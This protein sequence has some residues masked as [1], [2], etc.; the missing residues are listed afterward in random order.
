MA[1]STPL[2]SLSLDDE[3]DE[4][5]H[6]TT[7]HHASSTLLIAPL[8]SRQRSINNNNNNNSNSNIYFE[9]ILFF[10]AGLGSSIGYISSLSSLVYFNILYGNTYFVYLNCIIFLPLLPIS[11]FQSLLDTKFDMKY[12]NSNIT[13]LFRSIIGYGLLILGTIGIMILFW[14]ND[15]NESN[16]KQQGRWVLFMALQQGIGGAILYGQLNQLSSFV[17]SLHSTTATNTNNNDS[18]DDVNNENVSNENDSEDETKIISNK[19][20]ATV[21]AGV[22]ASAIVVLC[23]SIGSGFYDTMTVSA[24]ITFLLWIVLMEILCFMAYLWLL[25]AVPRVQ[26]SMIRRD[27]SMMH[28]EQ[29]MQSQSQSQLLLTTS[30]P[31][32]SSEEVVEEEEMIDLINNDNDFLINN[33]DNEDPMMPLRQPLLLSSSTATASSTTS[34]NNTILSLYEILYHSRYCCLGMGLTLIPSFLVGSWFTR[35]ETDWMMLAQILFYIRIGCDL[36]GRI[37]TLW[38]PPKSISY[39]LWIATI[40]WIAVFLFFINSTPTISIPIVSKVLPTIL[41]PTTQRQRDIVSILLVAYIAFCS[42]YLVTSLYQLAPQQLPSVPV[43][44]SLREE[45]GQEEEEQQQQLLL[46]PREG[47]RQRQGVSN[48]NT[49]NTNTVN[50]TKQSSI[51]TVAFSISAICGLLLSF[52]FIAIGV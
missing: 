24:F 5:Q 36:L 17:G 12:K 27:S 48:T 22:Q 4:D 3:D 41:V 10:M 32:P 45:E 16:S 43:P 2:L 11:I 40:R 38:V 6:H 42:G 37:C 13:F 33:N 46:L 47:Q 19:F 23:I 15:E 7:Q 18:N 9:Q 52:T 25:I 34:D 35:I 26:I 51:L 14:N 44:V 49:N 28:M 30:S 29:I 20:K 31:S 1:T 8:L 21:S 39:T 50:A